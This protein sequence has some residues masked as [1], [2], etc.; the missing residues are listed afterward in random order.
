MMQLKLQPH[1]P[2]RTGKPPQSSPQKA[3][4]A[5]FVRVRMT[6]RFRHF[7]PGRGPFVFRGAVGS[8]FPT[9]R[10]SVPSAAPVAR[11]IGGSHLQVK[12]YIGLTVRLASLV[13]ILLFEAAIGDF[14]CRLARLLRILR[15]LSGPRPIRVRHFPIGVREA[16][17]LSCIFARQLNI[18]GDLYGR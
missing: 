7:L 2:K 12:I 13:L 11:A 6:R 16:C 4:V 15:V 10:L 17:G 8:A 3:S 18:S 5:L 1:F 14:F 9:A